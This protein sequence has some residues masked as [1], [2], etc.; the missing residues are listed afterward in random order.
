MKR[1]L[2]GALTGVALS[3]SAFVLTAAVAAG[4]QPVGT[5][6]A[7]RMQHW[8]ADHQAMMDARLGGMK[9]AL[10]LTANQYPLWEIFEAA[11]RNGDKV[12][13]DDMRE[14]M[15][16][17]ERMS[18]PT[19]STSWPTIWLDAPPNSRRSPRRQTILRQHGRYTEAQLRIA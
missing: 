4:D 13:M 18:P 5:A 10:K 8:A 16:N 2:L 6:G 19:V 11:V 12:R 17:R 9:E 15:Q 14:M 7:E 3:V 1:I